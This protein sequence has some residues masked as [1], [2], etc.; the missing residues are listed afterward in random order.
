M[1][2]ISKNNGKN[3]QSVDEPNIKIKSSSYQDF[4]F[5]Q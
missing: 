1:A 5:L 4:D 3:N 2:L